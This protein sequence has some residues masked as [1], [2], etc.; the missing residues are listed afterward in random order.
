MSAAQQQ[1]AGRVAEG[2]RTVEEARGRLWVAIRNALLIELVL[3][4]GIVLAMA[5][6]GH[7]P[8]F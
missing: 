8:T 7:W 3:G 1:P 6:V 2:Q 5:A 4:G